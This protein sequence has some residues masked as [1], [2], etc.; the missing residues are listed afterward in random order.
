MVRAMYVTDKRR[1]SNS[2]A[3]ASRQV[4]ETSARIQLGIDDARDACL[5]GN[6]S[7]TNLRGQG[8][9]KAFVAR[10]LLRILL[11]GNA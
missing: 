5:G 8:R 7:I 6:G 9:A 3:F 11:D 1:W 2:R 4:F 10:R